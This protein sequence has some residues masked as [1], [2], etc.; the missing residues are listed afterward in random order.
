MVIRRSSLEGGAEASTC[1]SI[2]VLLNSRAGPH[3]GDWHV[4]GLIW[5]DDANLWYTGDLQICVR[6][7][8]SR[9]CSHVTNLRMEII[10]QG[11]LSLFPLLSLKTG[12]AAFQCCR[13]LAATRGER[14][15]ERADI[16]T[17]FNHK[18]SLYTKCSFAVKQWLDKLQQY[19][20]LVIGQPGMPFTLKTLPSAARW[21]VWTLIF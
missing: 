21:V 8:E 12:L 10:V 14:N 15:K 16:S 11:S 18:S 13:C 5:D 7:T 9:S 17:S 6:G 4:T 2:G 19:L 20:N 1:V 3:L